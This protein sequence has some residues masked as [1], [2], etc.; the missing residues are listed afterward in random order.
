[1]TQHRPSS[2]IIL[3]E[4]RNP[5]VNGEAVSSH[6][7][8]SKLDET[9]TI[10]PEKVMKA[11]TP[12]QSSTPS[13]VGSADVDNATSKT[14]KKSSPFRIKVG[15]VV[16]LRHDAVANKV[17]CVEREDNRDIPSPALENM[18]KQVL[19]DDSLINAWVDPIAGRD[20]SLA[21]IGKRIRCHFPKHLIGED[22]KRNVLEGEV[23]SLVDYTKRKPGKPWKVELLV[24]RGMLRHFSFLTRVDEDVDLARLAN[25]KARRNYRNELRI[26]GDNKVIVKM[27]L[28]HPESSLSQTQRKEANN[29]VQW[30]IQKRVPGKLF[31]SNVK[32][33]SGKKHSLT[34][35]TINGELWGNGEELTLHN[36][37]NGENTQADSRSTAPAQRGTTK[38]KAS[39]NKTNKPSRKRARPTGASPPP[40]LRHIGDGNDS[41]EQQMTNWRWLVARYHN[42]QNESDHNLQDVGISVS[43]LGL[44]GQVVK[45]EQPR[46]ATTT[47]ALVTLRR[48]LLPEHTR[49]GRLPHHGKFEVFDWPQQ[50][51]LHFT[52]PIE[53]LIMLGTS[54]VE[55]S[56][57]SGQEDPA[58]FP[59]DLFAEYSYFA[60]S[61]V[62]R[63]IEEGH[64]KP[65]GTEGSST[66]QS[67]VCHR[68]LRT[69]H[70]TRLVTCENSSCYTFGSENRPRWCSKC[71]HDCGVVRDEEECNSFDGLPCCTG[72]C[73]CPACKRHV[74]RYLNSRFRARIRA[75]SRKR[76]RDQRDED[77]EFFESAS[78]VVSS[79]TAVDF[80]LDSNSSFLNIYRMPA[81]AM[82]AIKRVKAKDKGL[83]KWRRQEAKK[84][85]RGES[86]KSAQLEGE[87]ED[88]TV[89]KS[90]CAREA[91]YDVQ[92]LMK[93]SI[94]Y[95]PSQYGDVPRNLREVYRKNNAEAEAG[96]KT[97][98]SRA[99]RAKQRRIVK[100]VASFSGLG[101]D[102]LASRESQLRFGRSGIHNW[103][104]FADSEIVAGDL[105]VE[106]R[107]EI[108]GN[109][110]AEKR[111]KEYEQA[112]IGSDYMFR[113][114]KDTVCDATKL[115]NVARFINASCD[116]NCYTKII[117]V[118]G[119]KRIVIYA[120]KDIREGDE[121]CY[122]YK[123]PL[124]YDPSKRIPCHCGALGCRGFM[125]WDKRYVE[126]APA[127]EA[128]GEMEP[129]KDGVGGGVG[130]Q[131]GIEWST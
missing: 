108:I 73:D 99:A 92:K 101:L 115:G 69:F 11:K 100:G 94:T 14:R 78:A 6:I 63:H 46:K 87:E 19:P 81:P 98:E 9:A 72:L 7:N 24:E 25:D 53:Q 124:E 66:D 35:T 50:D 42:L 91:A 89:F 130:G 113:I 71:I 118:E 82:N 65:N 112:K 20:E 80:A 51:N 61:N 17:Y 21:L 64:G 55:G 23:I 34:K 36:L 77:R 76:S 28:M 88:F 102:M 26:R 86:I 16:A 56:G 128:G 43:S 59:A 97:I 131:Q 54:L 67:S 109:A 90:T 52:V 44:V 106:Y 79:C 116:P 48:M 114:D 129:M 3:Y 123:F 29:C 119:N 120:K 37:S 41:P 39:T 27:R 70:E 8:V 75:R 47:L 5:K 32:N 49:T 104:V 126:V 4:E 84:G 125:N 33:A 15:C 2:R 83:K 110:R 127:S 1:M 121:L 111:E 30:V 96:D 31:Q 122:D 60:E 57:D 74:S 38:D 40:Q 13:V 62:Y 68:C 22:K 117:T 12:T 105:I 45:V 95:S 103:G 18:G 93:R 107:G 58:V 85:K 10:A